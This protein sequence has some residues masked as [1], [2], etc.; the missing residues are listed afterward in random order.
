[1]WI[2]YYNM[3]TINIDELE[4]IHEYIL[5]LYVLLFGI[6]F[7]NSYKKLNWLKSIRFPINWKLYM[8]L[9]NSA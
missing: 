1:M 3:I 4:F 8:S 6:L 5:Y 7:L 2:L 9:K